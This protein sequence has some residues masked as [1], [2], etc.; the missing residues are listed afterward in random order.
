M[1]SFTLFSA[2]TLLRTLNAGEFGFIGEDGSLTTTGLALNVTGPALVSVYGSIDASGG[3]AIDHGTGFLALEIGAV[4]SIRNT[5]S[6]DAVS[7]SGGEVQVANRGAIRSGEDALDLR[8]G[9]VRIVNDG[10]LRGGSDG[11][12]VDATGSSLEIFNRGS[13]RGVDDGGIDLLGGQAT[14]VNRGTI[15]GPA[16]GIDGS[17]GDENLENSGKISGGVAL[18]DGLD[19]VTNRGDIDT[20]DL[21]AGS[22]TY[23]GQG[24]GSADSVNAGTG[25]DWL[26]GS[27]ADDHFTG[28]GGA[29]YFSFAPRGGADVIEDFGV[30]DHVDLSRFGFDNFATDVRPFL[31]ERA[32]GVLLD[33]SD[34]G[35]TVLFAGLDRADLRASD[36]LFE[37][38]VA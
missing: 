4:G 33:L 38:S 19:S 25:R 34:E 18:Q 20:V 12:V 27:R 8:G 37:V 14:I 22:D 36:F 13:I 21:G 29:D 3:T 35:L 24:F 26:S 17:G 28:G 23:F 6:G 1:A 7:S 16:Y 31:E 15:A 9:E 2:E 30:V 10:V 11:V 5:G 32:G